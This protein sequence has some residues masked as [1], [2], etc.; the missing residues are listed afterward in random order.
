MAKASAR[1]TCR[2]S[3]GLLLRPVVRLALRQ[4]LKLREIVEYLK[5]VFVQLAAAELTR[6]GETV[7]ASRVSV[8]TGIQRP[9]VSRLLGQKE[10]PINN[11]DIVTRVIGL[12]QNSNR[13]RDEAGKPRILTHA[14]RNGEFAKLVAAVSTD[15]N[16]YTVA[17]ELVRAGIAEEHSKGLRLLKKGFEPSGDLEG[18]LALLAQ[19]SLDLYSAVEENI[20]EFPAQRNLHIKTEFDNIP[21]SKQELV[22][23]WFSSKGAA[24]HEEARAFLS[25]LDRDTNPPQSE[26]DHKTPALRAV[27]GTYSFTEKK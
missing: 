23:A 6:L 9:E 25:S 17:F 5:I 27:L 16:P 18:S 13:F 8:M 10:T 12:W 15:L 3:L 7:T 1:E 26:A 21:A 11:T 24:L 4:S 2:K 22:R 14:G 20:F 19:D